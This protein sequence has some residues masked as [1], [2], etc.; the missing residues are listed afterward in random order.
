MTPGTPRVLSL[1]SSP[2]RFRSF[3]KRPLSS[4]L[5]LVFVTVAS[6]SACGVKGPPKAPLAVTP[7]QSDRRDRATSPVVQR[8]PRELSPPAEDS[9]SLFDASTPAITPG[10]PPGSV[11]PQ[12]KVTQPENLSND[13]PDPKKPGEVAPSGT[14][15]GS[16]KQG[17]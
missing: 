14:S 3:L 9:P 7:A 12:G 17:A 4:F 5:C 8:N 11:T 15:Q 2:D 13:L 10:K 16:D 1:P 6:S